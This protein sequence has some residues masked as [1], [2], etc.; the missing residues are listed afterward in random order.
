MV[1]H[2]ANSSIGAGGSLLYIGCSGKPEMPCDPCLKKSVTT[3]SKH[4]G[5]PSPSQAFLLIIPSTHFTTE[6]FFCFMTETA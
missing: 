6:E 4:L 5:L 1:V 3:E 2:A